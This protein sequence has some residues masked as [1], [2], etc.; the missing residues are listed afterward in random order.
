MDALG[1]D[2]IVSAITSSQWLLTL[3]VNVLPTRCTF[4]VWDRVIESGHRAP[5]FAASCALLGGTDAK[6]KLLE[7]TEMDY[8]CIQTT[9]GLL[10][11]RFHLEY[12]RHAE[13]VFL[14]PNTYLVPLVAE[15]FLIS[16]KQLR[17]Y[18]NLLII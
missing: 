9:R 1:A 2:N 15:L 17:E 12:C 16:K 7:A 13:H 3:F 4:R 10:L 5:L 14:K 6:K 18:V 8:G 11:M